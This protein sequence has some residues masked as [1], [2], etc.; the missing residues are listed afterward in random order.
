MKRRAVLAAVAT[1]AGCSGSPSTTATR[2]PTVSPTST[3]TAT[4]AH[5]TSPTP[6]DTPTDEPTATE[7]PTPEGKAVA[8][9]HIDEANEELVDAVD[10]Y[11]EAAGAN[12]GWTEVGPD[13]DVDVE[14]V[15]YYL[16][17]ARDEIQDGQEHA[18]GEQRQRLTDINI[19]RR[20]IDDIVE[21]H[22]RRQVIWRN[23]TTGIES[24][25]AEEFSVAADAFD[26][27]SNRQDVF[28]ARIGDATDAVNPEAASATPAITADEIRQTI[29]VLRRESATAGETPSFFSE[30]REEWPHLGQGR[31][32]YFNGEFIAA[33]NEFFQCKGPFRSAA[34]TLGGIDPADPYQPEVDRIQCLSDA[35]ATTAEALYE[36]SKSETNNEDYEIK[37]RDALA[38]CDTVQDCPTAKSILDELNE[39]L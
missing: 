16:E 11:T 13:D 34:D 27:A 30:Y 22:G 17:R 38:A 31:D 32:F 6:T 9:D 1:M 12:S 25:I 2:S 28:E 20:F 7:S 29:D 19:V 36:G 4:P 18:V 23:V 24:T 39:R 37:A 26:T 15:Q 14:G 5:T 35:V 10:T 3:S 33:R 21:L 8:V